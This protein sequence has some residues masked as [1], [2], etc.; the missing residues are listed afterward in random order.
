[1]K[2]TVFTADRRFTLNTDDE[3]AIFLFNRLVKTLIGDKEVIQ[4]ELKTPTA[5]EV[6]T[7]VIP[8]KNPQSTCLVHKGFLYV[9]C[10]DC[11]KERG[12]CAKTPINSFECLECGTNFE[13]P[14]Q[15]ALVK[16][17]CKCGKYLK[18][19]T[20]ITDKSFDIPCL[21]CGSPNSVFFYEKDREYKNAG[22]F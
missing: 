7:V 18:Y 13:L 22:K 19:R 17:T 3:R 2:I 8:Q 15:M 14:E 11:G 10:P 12:F 5:S 21:E 1:M 4:T 9:R 6:S 20:N 16:F